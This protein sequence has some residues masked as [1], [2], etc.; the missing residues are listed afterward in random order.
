MRAGPDVVEVEAG[1]REQ[2]VAGVVLLL[3]HAPHEREA[4]R[5]HARRGQPEHDV[6]LLDPR[7]VDQA[8][9]VDEPDARARE[10]ELVLAVD[11]GELGRLAAQEQ[12]SRLPADLGGAFDELGHL[13]GVDRAGG[14]VVEQEERVGAG[15]EHVVDAVGREV[16]PARCRRPRC[17]A[18]ISFVP[19]LS[20]EAAS[21][22]RS[23][24][25]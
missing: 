10:V 21:R 18:R 6:A 12:A 2:V 4:V 13:L 22:R 5:V 24:S 25:G 11:A 9:T 14:D 19:T 3:E 15:R 23:S 1:R 7:A 20:V 8:V 16:G 17:R